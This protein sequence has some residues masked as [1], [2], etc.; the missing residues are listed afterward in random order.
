MGEMVGL[1]EVTDEHIR[2]QTALY[3][4]SDADL[5]KHFQQIEAN[6][7]FLGDY[8]CAV[9]QDGA[10]ELILDRLSI[11]ALNST[12]ASFWLVRSGL[13]QPSLTM[14]RDIMEVTYL[15]D[16]FSIYDD[17]ILV[18]ANCDDKK[19]KKEFSPYEIRLALDTAKNQT[20]SKRGELYALMCSH[21]AHADP[22]GFS[23]ISPNGLTQIGPFPDFS[24]FKACIEEIARWSVYL[25]ITF[26]TLRQTD[27]VMANELAIQFLDRT[28]TWVDIYILGKVP[29]TNKDT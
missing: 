15:L 7:L 4:N 14:V 1:G 3:L 13:Y 2:N 11:R 16:F 12:I 27:A 24:V 29:S 21:A 28:R 6:I 5:T 23:V 22:N 26:T 10:K 18:W 19:R 17:Q 25:S 8:L 20:N 9:S